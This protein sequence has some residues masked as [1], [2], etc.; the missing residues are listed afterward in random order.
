MYFK[1]LKLKYYEK[2]VAFWLGKSITNEKEN[3]EQRYI[4]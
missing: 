4:I 2:S 3:K 1:R